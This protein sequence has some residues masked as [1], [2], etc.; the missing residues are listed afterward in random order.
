MD[1]SAKLFDPASVAVIGASEDPRKPGGTIFGNLRASCARLYPVNP[2][3]SSISGYPCYPSIRDVPESVDLAVVAVPASAVPTVVEECVEKRA[4]VILVISGGFGETGAAGRE[5]ERHLVGLARANAARILGPNTVGIYVP[6]T[7]LDTTF[8][9]PN[10]WRRPP[11]GPVAL[12]CQSG[13]IGLDAAEALAASGSGISAMVVL[14]NKCD[15]DESDFVEVFAEDPATRCIALYLEDFA[16]GRRFFEVASRV[17]PKK[18]IV[19]AK[20]GRSEAGARAAMLHT[21]ALAQ[22]DRVVDGALRQAGV[23]RATDVADLAD[24]AR[25]LCAADPPARPRMAVLTVAGGYGVLLSDLLAALDHG[26]G[27]TLA[28]LDEATARRLR[29]LALPFAATQNPIDLTGSVTNAMLDH[30]L[31][32]L[33]EAPS[34]DA[35]LLAMVPYPPLMDEGV[36]DIVQHWHQRGPKPLIAVFTGRV[37]QGDCLRRLRRAGVLAY[38]DPW[39]AVRAVGA[40]SQRGSFLRGARDLAARDP[41][42]SDRRERDG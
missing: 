20:A 8:M 4:G 12:V 15:L 2:K 35:I 7:G 27:P 21:G 22:S 31:E 6:A 18:P 30:V 28:T 32:T 13:A 23:V 42:A 1:W 38:D 19:V 26:A 39:R 24:Y 41:G 10:V 36:I 3:A 17:S 29:E 37:Y 34:V 33:E 25:V 11:A 14:G 40:L 16:N 9:L 5:V